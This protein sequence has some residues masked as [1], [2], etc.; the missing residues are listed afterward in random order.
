MNTREAYFTRYAFFIE[1]EVDMAARIHAEIYKP[2]VVQYF[3]ARENVITMAMFQYMIGNN[4]WFV[5]S[6]HNTS[7]L[8]LEKTEEL[9]AVPYD[10]DWSMLVNANYTKP[11]GVPIHL[12]KDRRVY[13]GLCLEAEE[14]QNQQE[15][16]NSKEDILIGLIKGMHDLPEKNKKESEDLVD[17]FYEMLN[18]PSSLYNIFQKEECVKETIFQKK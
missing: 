9:I 13:K 1:N 17:R 16:F 10:F 11:K 3:L 5:T 2:N 15:L 4:D 8:K 18:K 12:V 7:I 6:K 14:L